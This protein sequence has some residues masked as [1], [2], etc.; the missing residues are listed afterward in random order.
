MSREIDEIRERR[1]RNRGGESDASAEIPA[2]FGDHEG[3]RIGHITAQDEPIVVDREDSR[4]WV[5]VDS[6]A[7]DDVRLG[8]YLRVPYPTDE[9]HSTA[10]LAGVITRLEYETVAD[11]TDKQDGGYRNPPG[12]QSFA[13]LAQVEP[14][15]TVELDESDDDD[16]MTQTTVDAPPKPGASVYLIENE[17]FLRTALRI[18]HQGAFVGHMAVSGDRIPSEDDPLPYYLFNPNATDENE[19]KGEPTVFRHIQVAGSTGQGKTHASKNVL[20]QLA[21]EKRYTIEVPPEEHE[22]T[23]TDIQDERVRGLNITVIDPEGEYVEMGENPNHNSY[24]ENIPGDSQKIRHGGISDDPD[25]DFEVFVP[26]IDGTN[27]NHNNAQSFGIPFELVKENRQLLY[28]S[29]PPE[30]TRSAINDVISDYFRQE[31]GVPTYTAFSEYAERM[32]A[33]DNDT[34]TEMD[35]VKIAARERIVDRYEYNRIFDHGSKSLTDLTQQMFAPSQV[36]VIPTDHLRGMTDRIVVSCLLAHIVKN[37]VGSNVAYPRIKGTPL[38]LALDEAHEYL[39]GGGDD[40]REN[41]LVRNF[42]QAAKRGR[43]DKFGLY[44]ITQTPQDINDDV[45][46]Q[47]NTRIYL[48]LERDVV[49]SHDV[50]V[51]PAFEEAVTQFNKGQMVV[52]QPNVRPV[53]IAG[54]NVCLTLHGS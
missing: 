33:E 35:S 31:N 26:V 43:K 19:D 8:T 18:P 47:M 4:V 5:F 30:R 2:P 36:T 45:R 29:K 1:N 9:E 37:K 13:Y 48:G 20:R 50:Y 7:R 14:I 22:A 12:E 16:A 40:P 38:L 34:I 51:P 42:Q 54:L 28:S 53:E 3:R 6:H 46:K 25:V 17:T 11:I 27:I 21:T 49:D 15:S 52:K 32:L 44:I 41:Y 10:M 24:T 39:T 23:T